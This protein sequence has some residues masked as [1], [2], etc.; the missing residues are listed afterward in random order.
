VNGDYVLFTASMLQT[1]VLDNYVIS[2]ESGSLELPTFRILI[3]FNMK[4]Y[5]S[6]ITGKFVSPATV[7]RHPN[8]TVT[9]T[10]KKGSQKK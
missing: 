6:A 10:V 1:Y 7:R 2:I 3:L 9:I 4:I 8:T 5:K